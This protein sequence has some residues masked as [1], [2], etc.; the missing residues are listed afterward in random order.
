M[1]VKTCQREQPSIRAASSNSSGTSSKA[2]II[3]QTTMGS[4]MTR[5][6]RMMAAYVSIHP[7]HWKR[8]KK[9]TT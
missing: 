9:G 5:W 2:P 6:D 1:R 4:V 8:M 3:T 7:S